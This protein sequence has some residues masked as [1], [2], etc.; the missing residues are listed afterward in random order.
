MVT[1]QARAWI[2]FQVQRRGGQVLAFNSGPDRAHVHVLI[3]LP[4]TAALADVVRDAKSMSSRL[5]RQNNPALQ[6]Q[7]RAFWGVSYWARTVGSGSLDQARRYVA[8]Q[9]SEE[10]KRKS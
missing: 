9:W 7:A 1:A 4:P 3:L 6:R 10:V 2:A 8:E 5:I